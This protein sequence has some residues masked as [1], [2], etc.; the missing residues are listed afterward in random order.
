[1]DGK[2]ETL[3]NESRLF[4]IINLQ[5]DEAE[6]DPSHLRS[7]AWRPGEAAKSHTSVTAMMVGICLV[8][9]S[10]RPP[11]PPRLLWFW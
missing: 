10:K 9:I 2:H 3:I 11:L 7:E 1:M 5:R 8:I 6:F 4:Y